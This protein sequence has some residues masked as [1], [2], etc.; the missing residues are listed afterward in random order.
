MRTMMFGAAAL[1][2][3]AGAACAQ[4]SGGLQGPVAFAAAQAAE[5]GTGVCFGAGATE[6]MQCAVDKCVAQ[7][8][9]MAED[10]GVQ[11]FCSSAQWSADLFMMHEQGIHWHDYL[12]GWGSEP[13]L[14]SAIQAKC[15]GQGLVECSAV[16]VWNPAGE[17]QIPSN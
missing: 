3:A 7:S 15:S 1:M 14:H 8:G 17:E 16:T 12:C 2:L 6:T 11:A 13:Q 4:A 10:C 9:L 5:A